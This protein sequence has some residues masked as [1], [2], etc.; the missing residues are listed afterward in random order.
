MA[1]PGVKKTPPQKKRLLGTFRPDRDGG[2]AEL[3]C[4]A[5]PVP[6]WL[7]DNER[8]HWNRIAP[9]LVECGLIT[10]L[11]QVAFA[12]LCMDLSDLLCAREIVDEIARTEGTKF[13]TTTDKGNVIQH[14]A[15]GVMNKAHA[16]VVKLLQEF[17]MTPCARAGI[18]INGA[19]SSDDPLKEFGVVA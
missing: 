19:N 2:T 9:W 8:V 16:R 17:G 13:I 7:D 4:S 18:K 1:K 15:V 12:L 14:P 11:D 5:P 6:P 3:S 10:K